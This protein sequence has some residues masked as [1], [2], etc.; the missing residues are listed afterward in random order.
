MH[1]RTPMV[2]AP[3]VAGYGLRNS[4]RGEGATG[5][6]FLLTTDYMIFTPE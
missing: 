3:K 6:N 4:V 5:R 1:G 2:V